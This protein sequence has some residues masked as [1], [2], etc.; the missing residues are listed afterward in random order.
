MGIE[1]WEI[2]HN[3]GLCFM[4]LKLYDEAVECFQQA[5]GIQRHDATYM[6]LGKVFTL[7]EDIQAAIEIYIEALEF[8]PENAE[9]LTTVGLLYLRLGE[10][11]RAFDYLGKYAKGDICGLC[12]MRVPTRTTSQRV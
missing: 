10:N 1:D 9:I 11:Y 8:S 7:K 2:W 3:K 4:Y 6:Q 12:K 5:N